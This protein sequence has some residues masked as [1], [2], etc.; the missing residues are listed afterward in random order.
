MCTFTISWK[1]YEAF[2]QPSTSLSRELVSLLHTDRA[3]TTTVA[4]PGPALCKAAPPPIFY[5]I[6]KRE[7]H[8]S[9]YLHSFIEHFQHTLRAANRHCLF[10]PSSPPTDHVLHHQIPARNTSQSLI[11]H[12]PILHAA[13]SHTDI[14]AAMSSL[15]HGDAKETIRVSM[16][17]AAIK[18]RC[19]AG[20]PGLG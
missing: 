6:Q 20:R 9:H 4:R 12:T 13:P 8:P 14:L 11:P 5:G 3:D 2:S 15:L 1:I 19:W 10:L 7:E 18:Y 17:L 16:G